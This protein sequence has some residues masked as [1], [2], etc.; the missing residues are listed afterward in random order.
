MKAIFPKQRPW[1][2]EA[3]EAL[4]DMSGGLPEFKEIGAKQLDAAVALHRMLLAHGC[5]YLADEVGMGKTYVALAIVALFRRLQPDFRV[6]Y[7]APTANVLSKWEKRELPAFMQGNVRYAVMHEQDADRGA[8]PDSRACMNV[9]A[10]LECAVSERARRDVFVPFSALSFQLTGEADN[11]YARV[12]RLAEYGNVEVNLTGVSHKRK[13]KDRAAEVVNTVIPPYD[14]VIIDEAHLLKSGAG[15]GASDR[16]QFLARALGAVGHGG[17]RRFRAAL[18]LSGTPFDRDLMQ[19]A[20]QFELFAAPRGRASEAPHEVIK[21]LAARRRQGEQWKTIQEG[22]K[23]YMVRRVQK[24]TIGATHLSRNQYRREFR[25]EAGISLAGDTSPNVLQQRIFTAVVQKRLIE[26]VDEVHAGHFPMAMFSSWEAYSPPVKAAPP[27]GIHHGDVNDG[28]PSQHMGDMLDVSKDND[29]P[30]DARAVDGTLIEHVVGSY[31][32][33]FDKQPPHP[34]LEVEANRLGKEAFVDGLKQ[35][36]FVRRLK[37]VDDL[38]LRLN[39]A[40]DVQL[41]EY[42]RAEGMPGCPNDLMNSRRAAGRASAKPPVSGITDGA[43]V[44]GESE[45]LPPNGDTLF[46]WFFRGELDEEGQSFADRHELRRPSQLRERL[47]DDGRLESIIGELD[48]RSFLIQQCP[49][50]PEVSFAEL[51]AEAAHIAGPSSPL[52]RYRRLQAAWAKL[53]SE[54][55][56]GTDAGR[57]FQGL[58]AHLETLCFGADGRTR[59][60]D[61]SNAE[62]LLSMPTVAME[63][64]RRGMGPIFLPQ[65][66]ATWEAIASEGTSGSGP[67]AP[68][69][70]LASLDLL[71]EVMFA[72]LRLDHPFVDL[73][74]GWCKGKREDGYDSANCL[75]ERIVGVCAKDSQGRRFGT[76][77]ILRNLADS[78]QQIVKTNFS[79]VLRDTVRSDW[80]KKIREQLFPFAPVEWASGQN[81]DSRSVIARRFRMPG[82]PMVLVST[83]VLQE[84]ED[85]HVNCDRVTHFGISGSPIGIEQKNGRVDRIGSRA[86]RRLLAGESVA[87]AGI[88][89]RFPHLTESLE[90]FQIRDLSLGINDYLHSIH[91]VGT[92]AGT[93]GSSQLAETMANQQPIPELLRD[94]LESPFEPLW[95]EGEGDLRLADVILRPTD[96]P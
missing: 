51:A 16:A 15:A 49:E 72:L 19:L 95:V 36:V 44:D 67:H 33:V 80:R 58:A 29:G 41:A 59:A 7:L 86:Q 2:R 69:K 56:R 50:L 4:L 40:Y 14:L 92:L 43:R 54:R 22:L 81:T 46:T 26:H 45:A 64:Y 53:Q 57:P 11:W 79:D 82:Y 68:E 5:A 6:L 87:D 90:W 35:L 24:L 60:I 93:D 18:L 70:K 88:Q 83:S 78:W 37:S 27:S 17:R 74:L 38:Y 76:A 91:E 31:R 71:R 52:M 10:W 3:A 42:L 65:W 55:L 39:E 12:K 8:V 9:E 94:S 89:V 63:L 20:R 21:G 62:A 1:T 73:Y 23:P 28:A 30:R 48:W 34:K 25:A 13:F 96:A 84:G 66:S 47:R 75:V 32:D 85:L 77:S 61:A